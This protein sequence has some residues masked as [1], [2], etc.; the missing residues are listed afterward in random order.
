MG[1][2]VYGKRIKVKFT[3][4][5]PRVFKPES[6]EN[7]A[8]RYSVMMLIP[9]DGKGIV[10]IKKEIKRLSKEL[11][12]NKLPKNFRN[13]IQDGDDSEYEGF[14]NNWA[15]KAGSDE[16]NKPRIV[17]LDLED[18]IDPS[19][20]YGGCEM[21]AMVTPFAYDNIGRG[22]SFLLSNMQKIADGDRIGGSDHDPSDD[23]GDNSDDD[24]DW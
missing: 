1:K 17:D 7:D 21:A 3:A 10:P 2:N 6:F 19:E 5:F 24:S 11:F 20:I 13:P 23:F 8:P 9:K 16:N 4:A 22:V 15:I 18:I 12:G 14:E